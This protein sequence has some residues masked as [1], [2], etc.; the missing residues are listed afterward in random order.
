MDNSHEQEWRNDG[1][2]FVNQHAHRQFSRQ[3][4]TPPED[5]KS[6]IPL[7]SA[8]L[9]LTAS[10]RQQDADTSCVDEG[11]PFQPTSQPHTGFRPPHQA[12]HAPRQPDDM[13]ELQPPPAASHATG[14]YLSH[15]SALSSAQPSLYSRPISEVSSEGTPTDTQIAEDSGLDVDNVK[16]CSVSPS[17]TIYSKGRSRVS[18][19]EAQSKSR[20]STKMESMPSTGATATT[21]ALTSAV[22][23]GL[24]LSKVSSKF[25][26]PKPFS[27]A[28]IVR[29]PFQNEPGSPTS[30]YTD[31]TAANNRDT[32]PLSSYHGYNPRESKPST[33]T[34]QEIEDYEKIHFI[35]GLPTPMSQTSTVSVLHN[36][37]HDMCS[38]VP[39]SK[40]PPR[41]DIAAVR[42]AEARGSMTSLS[43]LIKRATRLAS[44][45]DRGKTASRLGHLDM[46][47]SREKLD[48]GRFRN[49]TYSDVLAAFPPPADRSPPS[50]RD[51]P[52][53]M[54]PGSG[55][56]FMMSKSSLG[57]SGDGIDNEKRKRQCC[58][59]SPIM[60][61]LILL[62]LVL[63]IAA[64]VLIPVFLIVLPKQHQ[65]TLGECSSSHTCRNNGIAV[66]INEQCSCIC[67]GGF[68]GST[69]SQESDPECTTASLHDGTSNFG[70]ATIGTAL[71]PMLRPEDQ[72]YG[73]PL[74]K[75]I[76]LATFAANN[77]SCASENSLVVFNQNSNSQAKRSSIM[78]NIG[79]PS[80]PALS[81]GNAEKQRR[82]DATQSVNGIVFATSS[83]QSQP[84]ATSNSVPT[85]ASTTDNIQNIASND[86]L[87][88]AAAVVLYVL[89][90]NSEINA[91][92]T[93]KQAMSAYFGER[94]PTNHTV[95]VVGGTQRIA[96]NFDTFQINL[97]NGT[98]LGGR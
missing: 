85:A 60:F 50:S 48:T 77:L 89:Q 73:I 3:L 82:Q 83:Q 44:N 66:I 38:K 39:M 42:E 34:E 29:M 47:G 43:D 86:T 22:R 90:T 96:V 25:T 12:F 92:V 10:E 88:F 9:N 68:T 8:K 23:Q 49:S 20:T 97:A 46:F 18:T 14:R 62:V 51:R 67:T 70:N 55:K 21:E 5:Q 87:N 7:R 72:T 57:G 13:T 28:L 84:T 91:A 69:C 15:I 95:V 1:R 33:I 61:V 94:N 31:V 76:I 32:L 65:K 45:L 19:N 56:Q 63:L 35:N 26:T 27:D 40:R 17:T 98:N 93:A 79:I 74:N 11:R 80:G 37:G 75:T 81:T 4:K 52:A 30:V 53:T 41:L 59:L 71:L 78:E 24:G 36:E 2:P 58:G 64:A 54:W 6:R 16:N